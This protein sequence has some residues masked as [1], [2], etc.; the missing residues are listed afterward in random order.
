V[1]ACIESVPIFGETSTPA[2]V[3]CLADDIVCDGMGPEGF[4]RTELHD[5]V[6]SHSIVPQEE[7]VQ[8]K[9]ALDIVQAMSK[10]AAPSSSSRGKDD[11]KQRA[12]RINRVCRKLGTRTHTTRWFSSSVFVQTQRLGGILFAGTQTPKPAMASSLLTLTQRC[13]QPVVTAFA[14]T[15]GHDDVL[16]IICA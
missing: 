7:P 3:Q 13:S 9:S 14:L 6:L 2:S 1:G 12:T 5:S 10:K 4:H 15:G 11:G 8:A 16:F